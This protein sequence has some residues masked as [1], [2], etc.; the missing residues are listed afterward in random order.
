MSR[1]LNKHNFITDI[2]NIIE[3]GRKSAYNSISSIMIETYWKIGKR[4]IE[5]EQQG[6]ERADYGEQL[7]NNLSKQ[8]TQ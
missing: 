2:K 8:L 1:E 7:I 5:E 6:K 4:I 3:Q